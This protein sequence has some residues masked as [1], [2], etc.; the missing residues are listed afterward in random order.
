MAIRTGEFSFYRGKTK[1]SKHVSLVKDQEVQIL[2][3]RVKL[4]RLYQGTGKD[5]HILWAQ[6]RFCNTERTFGV[7]AAVLRP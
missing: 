1:R 4:I 6:V 3:S 7:P 5:A 2:G